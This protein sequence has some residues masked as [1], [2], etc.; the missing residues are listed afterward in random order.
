MVVGGQVA[1]TVDRR[2]EGYAWIKLQHGFLDWWQQTVGVHGKTCHVLHRV[3]SRDGNVILVKQV[4][5]RK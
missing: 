3:R 1:V 2:A 4:G 5:Q